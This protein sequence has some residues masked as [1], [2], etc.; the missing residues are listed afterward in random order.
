MFGLF[1]RNKKQKPE[2]SPF[3]TL[4]DHDSRIISIPNARTNIFSD[5]YN[6]KGNKSNT[7]N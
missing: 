4:E 3:N 6:L 5:G 2:W 7:K 1:N